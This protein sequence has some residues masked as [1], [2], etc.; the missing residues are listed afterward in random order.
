MK[1]DLLDIDA[2]IDIN[3]LQ[4]IYS[5]IIFQRGGV[6]SPNGLLSN[7]IFGMNVKQR[8]STFAYIDLK[9]HLLHPHAYKALIRV[10]PAIDRIISGANYV[11]IVDGKI[12]DDPEN[13]HTGLEYI[14]E[15][16]NEIKWERSS[17]EASMRKERLDV[18]TEVP[19][20]VL[21]IDKYIVIPVFYRDINK[22]GG[23]AE[24]D[25]LNTLYTKI[26]RLASI[27]GGRDMFDF[28]YHGNIFALQRL[29]VELYD[30]FKHKLERKNGMIRKYLMGKNVSYCTRSVI[31]NPLFH[32]NSP[33]NLEIPFDTVGVPLGQ[34]CVL[35]YPFI[36]RWLKN[37]FE[38]EFIAVQEIK[39]TM[40]IG[41]NGETISTSKIY[42]PEIYFDEKYIRNLVDSYTSDPESRFDPILVPIIES[43]ATKP[44]YRPVAFT[45]KR[46]KANSNEEMSGIGTRPLTATDLLFLAATDS[47][48]GKHVLITR[49]PVMDVY[50]MFVA[51][52]RPIATTR[53]ER[54]IINDEVYEYYPYID[55][56]TPRNR[57]HIRFIDS[58]QF[59][60]SYLAAM[61]GDH[62]GDQVTIK[63][64]WSQEANAECEKVM[65]EKSFFI[66]AQGRNARTMN[67]EVPQT[68]YD[69]TKDPDE[70]SKKAGMILPEVVKELIERPGD[71]YTFDYICDLIAFKAR[72]ANR[73]RQYAPNRALVIPKGGVGNS[74]PITTTLGRLIF[75]KVIIEAVGLSKFIS[76]DSVNKVLIAKEFNAIENKITDLLANE[77]I[78]T[79]TFAKYVNHRDW[80]G[81]QLHAAVTVS[82]TSKTAKTPESVKQLRSELFEKYSKELADGDIVVANKIE[83]ELIDKMLD[84]IKDDPG[85]DIYASGARGTVDNHM[86]NMFIM[87]G[88]V[89]NPNTG[90]YD[91]METSFTDG[92]RKED[93]TPASNSVVHGAYPKA[94]GTADSGY[95]AKQ[96]MSA[97]QGEV[98]DEDG[99]DCG[100]TITLD[101]NI[102]SS[103]NNFM[104]RYIEVGGKPLLLTQEN[105]GQYKNKNVK[106]YTP[107]Y[108]KRTKN[109]C[110]CEKCAGKQTSK[111]PG[112]DSNRLGTVLTKLNMKKFHVTNITFATLHPAE[113]F[114]THDGSDQFTVKNGK[115]VTTKPLDIIVPEYHYKNNLVEELGSHMRLFGTVSVKL[116]NGEYDML[117]V[118]SWHNYN[119]YTFD[120]A[121][122][123][124]PGIGATKARIF[125]YDAGYELCETMIVQ[126]AENAQLFLKQIIHGKIPAT[127]PQNKTLDYWVRNQKMNLVNF[128]V[129]SLIFEVILSCSYRY[130]KDP[131]K[132][133]GVVYAKNPG[134]GLYAYEMASFR[135]ICQ[136]SSTFAGITFESFDD[137]TTS[138]INRSRNNTEEQYSPL[139]M[140]LKL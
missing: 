4:E 73:Y 66:T 82:F 27:I 19:R 109:G 69:I 129:P 57:M 134:I 70:E 83:N 20:S 14:Y 130:K 89:S 48:R 1:I 119:V 110:I 97:M 90:K 44:V 61:D 85:Y 58:C 11:S 50:G 128:G 10:Y 79:A 51:R 136:L 38:R 101:V 116:A 87:R 92:L 100:T 94:C 13:G 68:M 6:P 124:L 37:F 43:G 115:L 80:L 9:T 102:G 99:S 76:F 62:D 105:I 26:I 17:D 54:V 139:E 40:D 12:V 93:F 98:I 67:Y 63:V 95:L 122:V 49:Y 107:M 15:H 120:T 5:P 22:S 59:S 118:P 60:N 34:A 121:T 30:T 47:L 112:L 123:E 28:S 84:E 117:N 78:T 77:K 106:L 46:L 16:W 137:M 29:L 126:D 8:R 111:F 104:N 53:T 65:N 32:A 39:T 96:L 125:H 132:K 7:E 133:F 75:Y 72:G 36:V 81:L 71:N 138:A 35:V 3:G 56:T 88:G 45:G 140:L 23:G 74:V 103:T 18:I 24:T 135:R 31:S 131:T 52:C 25:P 108:C 86:K 33:D 64:L 91:I 114:V 42:K 55:T 21:F 113:M 41:P 2:F 127:I